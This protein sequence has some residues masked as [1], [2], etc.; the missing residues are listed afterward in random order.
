MFTGSV[1]Q[2]M[3]AWVKSRR[4][5]RNSACPLWANSGLMHRNRVHLLF[6]HFV[7]CD[8]QLGRYG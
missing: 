8:E 3:S 2:A 6:D 1:S 4:L 7:R 5:Q